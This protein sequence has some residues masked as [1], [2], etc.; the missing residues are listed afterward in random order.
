M[1]PSS[2]RVLEVGVRYLH[3]PHQCHPPPS[4][5]GSIIILPRLY[6]KRAKKP[7]I[8]C[9]DV[10]G[11]TT[12][13]GK[14]SWRASAWAGAAGIT[15]QM[16]RNPGEG[17]VEVEAAGLGNTQTGKSFCI[18][19][20]LNTR[21]AP[22]MKSTI[23]LV[24][25]WGFARP[26]QRHHTGPE[27]PKTQ[28]PEKIILGQ[29]PVRWRPSR[30]KLTVNESLLPFW[31]CRY[32]L[33]SQPLINNSLAHDCWWHDL[34][35]PAKLCSHRNAH[36]YHRKKLPLPQCQPRIKARR[37]TCLDAQF[38]IKKGLWSNQQMT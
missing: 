6:E 5:A 31:F 19:Q 23:E 26:F 14:R 33:I 1:F 21:Q 29:C 4:S 12:Q 27:E 9:V 10:C 17:A 28:S 32:T 37:H 20:L 38:G 8:K 36:A 24:F 22:E 13:T 18:F 16:L 34:I 7:G 30:I 15:Q 11:K 3:V 25:T 2:K 35:C